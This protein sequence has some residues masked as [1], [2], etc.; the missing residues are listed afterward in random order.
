[1][2]IITFPRSKECLYFSPYWKLKKCSQLEVI[3]DE[4]LKAIVNFTWKP[5]VIKLLFGERSQFMFQGTN[6]CTEYFNSGYTFMFKYLPSKMTR[7]LEGVCS[8]ND[9]IVCRSWGGAC[10][11][12]PRDEMFTLLTKHILIDALRFLYSMLDLACFFCFF[13]KVFIRATRKRKSRNKFIAHHQENA[14]VFQ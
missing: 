3:P 9:V 14:K 10:E 11:Q 12:E 1:M 7:L 5:R 4:N 13:F 6:K 2:H 8:Q